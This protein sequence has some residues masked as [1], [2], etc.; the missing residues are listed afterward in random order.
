MNGPLALTFQ[1]FSCICLSGLLLVE[2]MALRTL[3]QEAFL[4]NH[5]YEPTEAPAEPEEAVLGTRAQPFR[6][7]RLDSSGV[8]TEKD[9]LGQVTTL[10]FVMPSQLVPQTEAMFSPLLHSIWHKR[11]GPVYVVCSGSR[12][13]C[14]LLRDKYRFGKVH[15]SG[16]D[17]LFDEGAALRMTFSVT[18]AVR[19]VVIDESGRI[20]KVGGARTDEF[21]EAPSGPRS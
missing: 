13:D 2:W 1:T 18:S 17:V 16:V 21:T 12:E 3:V 7:P 6:T 5:L 8:F 9:L 20:A 19:A 15:N 10:L 11:R 14:Q 4:L